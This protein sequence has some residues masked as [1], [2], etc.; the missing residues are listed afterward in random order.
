[1]VESNKITICYEDGQ[2]NYRYTYFLNLNKIEILIYDENNLEIEN[3]EFDVKNDKVIECT[4]GKCNNYKEA[5]KLFDKEILYL[6][7]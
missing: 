4:T 7:K 2:Y 5:L 1:M 6:L 3:Y